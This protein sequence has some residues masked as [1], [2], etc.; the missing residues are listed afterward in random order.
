VHVALAWAHDLYAEAGTL[1]ARDADEPAAQRWQR[2]AA[3]FAVAASARG[4]RAARAWER[5]QAGG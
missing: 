5:L 1:W 2:D 3:L 4:L